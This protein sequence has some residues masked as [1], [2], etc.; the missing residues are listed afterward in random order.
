MKSVI[1]E[2]AAALLTP[3]IVM[4]VLLS[5][6]SSPARADLIIVNFDSVVASPSGTLFPGN[7][8]A[9]S[10]VT[11]T[12]GSIPNT[13]NVG[14]TITFSNA[15]NQILIL[16]NPDSISPPNFAAAAGVFGVANDVL[17]AFSTPVTSVQLTT[18]DNPFEAPD[19][20]RLLALAPTANPNQFVVLAIA[21][22]LDNAT[23][24]P[25][26]ML[27][28]SLG[29]VPF[30]FALFQ[31]TTEAEGFDDLTFVTVTGT[32]VPEPSSLLLCLLG[33]GGVILIGRRRRPNT[34]MAPPVKSAHP[35]SS[36]FFLCCERATVRRSG[37]R[38][39]ASRRT[40]SRGSVIAVAAGDRRH[41]TR[42]GGQ[43]GAPSGSPTATPRRRAPE[44][45]P[46]PL[47]A[48]QNEQAGPER[49]CSTA[50]VA[51]ARGLPS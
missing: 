28:V 50:L 20:V 35:D 1:H 33:V 43:A 15:V 25:D 17:M 31:V 44:T 21:E 19:I 3:I 24:P 39:A 41:Q 2:R 18:D 46:C 9:A 10:G 37:S 34:Y 4:L 22:G 30:S 8:F 13:V 29:G 45:L 49:T 6:A 14:D 5:W 40:A 47:T 51:P 23:M 16:G 26:N 36:L 12:S 7:T 32:A 27:S 48:E 38:E 11:F 42:M